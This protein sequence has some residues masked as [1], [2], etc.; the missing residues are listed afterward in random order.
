MANIVTAV[1]LTWMAVASIGYVCEEIK[2]HK[3]QK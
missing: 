2:I 3:K 1:L